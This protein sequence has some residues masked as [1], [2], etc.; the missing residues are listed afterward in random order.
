MNEPGGLGRDSK[1]WRDGQ[2]RRAGKD[3]SRQALGRITGRAD[4]ADLLGVLAGGLAGADL[5]TLL[6][7]VFRR[8]A[9]R[10]SPAEVMRRYRTDRFVAPGQVSATALRRAENAMLGALPQGFDLVT[11]A[12]VLPLGAHTATAGVDPRNVIATVRG[13]EVAADPTNGL[14]LEAAARRAD[15]LRQVPRSAEPV[16]LAASQRVT[17]AQL[18]SGPVSFAHFQLLG[19]VTAGRDTGGHEFETRHLTEQV[20]FAAAGLSA[21]GLDQVTIAV[22]CLDEPSRQVLAAVTTELAGMSAI[23]VTEAPDRESGRAY[24]R[25][26][27]FKVYARS[28]RD[29]EMLELGDGGFVD[30]TANLLGNRKERMVISGYGIDRLA[31]LGVASLASEIAQ[32][33]G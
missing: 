22:T 10:L 11:L 1:D 15:L 12:P 28:G 25:G 8:R 24:Y 18:F 6:L 29:Q 13:T 30:W 31:L 16:R 4:G 21:L 9:E 7:E 20:R 17:R 14:A 5:T 32:Q 2:E 3:A 19:V 26:L 23:E 33:P 27:C